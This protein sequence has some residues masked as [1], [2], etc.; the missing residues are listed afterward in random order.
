MNV[1]KLKQA[2]AAFLAR[3]PGG[4]QHPEMV[5]MGKKHK[6]DRMV[7]QVQQSFARTRFKDTFAIVDDI[8]K[9]IGRSSMVSMFEK[10]KF[11][12]FAKSLDPADKNRLAT[13]LRDRLHGKD[14]EKKQKG[15]NTMLAP[16][17]EHKLAK[18]SL[19]SALPLYFRPEAEVFVKPTTAKGVIEYF[20]LEGLEYRPQPT[21]EFY[22]AYREAILKM[23]KQVSQSLAPN[24]AAFTG[25]LMMT[26]KEW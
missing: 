18:W 4:F 10:P 3:Y 23:K 20:E 17:R 8:A 19:I 21:W 22:V 2:E 1:S 7:E 25:F 5:A 6:M 24:N 15:F 16:L 14:E 13:G 12:D 11:R 26:M 9:Y